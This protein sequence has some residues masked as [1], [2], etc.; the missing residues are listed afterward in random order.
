MKAGNTTLSGILTPAYRYVIPLFQRDYVWT[1]NDWESLWD[2]VLE[3]RELQQQST[4]FM[5]AIVFAAEQSD[6]NK[7]H[8]YQVIDGQQRLS[9]CQLCCARFV[10]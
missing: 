8:T 9:R 2:D 10:T 6:P 4:H 7:M 3:L 5:G 1:K